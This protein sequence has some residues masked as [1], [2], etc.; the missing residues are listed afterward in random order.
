MIELNVPVNRGGRPRAT[1]LRGVANAIFYL[2]KTG[3]PWRYL[4]RDF[5]PRSTVWRYFDEWRNNGTLKAIRYALRTRARAAE[6]IHCPRPTAS[7]NNQ[8]VDTPLGREQPGP[9]LPG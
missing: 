6:K 9:F 1:D 7:V 2:L 8:S 4:P 5:L 3:C